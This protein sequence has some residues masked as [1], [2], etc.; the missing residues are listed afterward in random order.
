[1]QRWPSFALALFLVG[2]SATTAKV[3]EAQAQRTGEEAP[4]FRW[5]DPERGFRL[6][7]VAEAGALGVLSHRIRYGEA[8]TRVNYQRDADQD[9]LFFFARLS[10]EI[11]IRRRHTLIFLYQPLALNTESV[12]DRDLVVGSVT[13]P[14]GRP[15]RFG[16]GFDF[17]R[18][19]YQ[20]DVFADD[21]RELAFGG[22]FQIRNARVSFVTSDGELA[23]TQTNVGFVP[24]LRMR[25]RYVFDR[26][27]FV[28]GEIDGWVSPIPG[29]R[30]D[31]GQRP[32]GA[33]LDASLR[34]GVITTSFSEVF[35]NLRY[36][37]G[38]Y[39]G[40]SPLDTGVPED[41]RWTSNWLHTMTVS[42]GFG[43]R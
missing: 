10:G 20:Y 38:G 17:Y 35:L 30:G 18:V 32:L 14:A 25:G 31:G 6:R 4:R 12:P 13:F 21:R 40:D 9:T 23:F 15:T 2:A 5:N 39:R 43:L 29:G 26:G 3:A 42:L 27:V 37:G 7:L 22:G 41:D 16:Y 36:L 19:A 33:L 34:A 28:G 8:G 24:L 11:E 1:M